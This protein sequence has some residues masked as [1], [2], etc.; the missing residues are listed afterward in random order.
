M[1]DGNL[2]IHDCDLCGSKDAVE[3]EVISNYTG[4]QPVHVCNVCG[5]V[6][7]QGR[8]SYEEISAAWSDEVYVSAEAGGDPLVDYTARIPAIRARQIYVADFINDAIGFKGKTVCD[9]GAGEGQFLEI[10]QGP[11]YGAKVL[12]LEP[13]EKNCATMIAAGLET[14]CGSIEDCAGSPTFKD[15]KFDVITVVWTVENC[16]SCCAMFDACY[17]LLADGGYIAVSTGSRI[18]VPFKKPLHYFFGTEATDLHNFHFSANSLRHLL[19]VSGFE[20]THIN[21]YIDTDYLVAIGRKTDKAKDIP[22][23]KDDYLDVIDFFNRW[24][25]DTQDHYKDT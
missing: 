1:S 9:I 16:Q 19:A 17:D 3:I 23:V 25:K 22:W 11:D 20:T 4:G 15:R 2:Q 6:H 13:S 12:G 5:F 10:I 18:L 21:R 14:F 24:D 7:V 8:R